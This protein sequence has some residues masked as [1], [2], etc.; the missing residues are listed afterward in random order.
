MKNWLFLFTLPLA[1]SGCADTV[2]RTIYDRAIESKME[3]EKQLATCE[4]TSADLHR[5]L[6]GLRHQLG[7]SQKTIERQ[8]DLLRPYQHFAGEMC[9]AYVATLHHTDAATASQRRYH[10]VLDPS[11]VRTLTELVVEV[12]NGGILGA[13][14]SIPGF[15]RHASF[16]ASISENDVEGLRQQL[17]NPRIL[18]ATYRLL[19]PAVTNAI[20]S[21]CGVV[22]ALRHIERILEALT[23]P[24]TEEQ[25]AASQEEDLAYANFLLSPAA[26]PCSWHY[27]E[28]W[29]DKQTA[30]VYMHP[31]DYQT[32]KWRLRREA[33]GGQRLVD[34]W[35]EILRDL[36]TEL[37]E[38]EL[39][40]DCNY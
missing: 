5:E 20:V 10:E 36:E 18:Q 33:E 19:K 16:R 14:P 39:P 29:H 4:S 37:Q 15:A 3:A 34:A 26:H 31:H 24:L 8:G 38:A 40:P 35:I 1:A 9:D 12:N 23:L 11:T 28:A 7:V 25:R 13:R 17:R 22:P 2:N 21:D 32:V 6:E 30:F 27:Q